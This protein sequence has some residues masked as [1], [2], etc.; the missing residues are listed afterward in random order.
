MK[1][2]Q[3]ESIKLYLKIKSPKI[4]EEPYYTI[5]NTNKIFSLKSIEKLK[6]KENLINLTLDEIFNEENTINDIYN[7]TCSNVIKESLN[8]C[9]FCL[10]NHGETISDKL[11]TFMGDITNVDN[12]N[13]TKGMFQRLYLDLINYIEQNKK[14][15]SNISLQISFICINNSKVIDLNNFLK[16]DMSNLNIKNIIQNTKLIQ[17]DK[18]L[19][20]TLK[21]I[22]LTNANHSHILKYITTIISEFH[23][24][25]TDY[26]SNS[27][28]SIIIYIDKKIKNNITHISSISFILLNGSEKLNIVN[29]VKIAKNDN[30]NSDIK[31]RAIIA[32]KNAISTQH[33]YNSIIYL[34]KKNKVF[35]IDKIK[36]KEKE[37]LTKEEIKEIETMEGRYISSLTALLYN[38]CFDYKIENIKYIIFADIYPNVGYYKSIKDSILFLFD[39]SKILNKNIKERLNVEKNNNF[40]ETNFM[41]DLETKINQQEQTINAL[42]EICQSKNKKI[43]NL[44]NVYDSQITRLKKIFGFEGDIGIL[45]SGEKSPEAEKAKNIRESGN[46]IYSLNAKIKSMEKILKKS[47]DEIEKYKS[48][49]KVVESDNNMIKYIEGIKSMKEDKLNDMH[50]KSLYGNKINSLESELKNKN[51][52]INQLKQDLINKNNIIQKLSKFC[53]NK[54]LKE[55]E[56]NEINK[57]AIQNKEEVNNNTITTDRRNKKEMEME[58]IIKTYEKKIK[59]EHDFWLAQIENKDKDIKTME[60]K[61]NKFIHKEKEYEN[62]IEQYKSDIN[63]LNEEIINLKQGV[64][65]NNREMMKLNELLMEIINNYNSYFIHKSKQN[66]NFVSLQNKIKEFNTYITEKEKEI[67]QLN[68]PLLH[69][70]LEKNNKLSTNYKTKVDRHIKLNLKLNKENLCSNIS[71]NTI[72]DKENSSNN[73]IPPY[74]KAEINLT[75]QQLEEMSS[76]K[77]IEYCLT[78]I[79]RVNDADKYVEKC[80]EIK[81]ENEENKKQIKYLNFKL[82]RILAES[83][84]I[85][86]INKN[87]KIVIN[88][89]NRTIEKFQ[90]DKL[91]EMFLNDVNSMNNF[92]F[93]FSPKKT[94]HFNKSQVNLKTYNNT[95]YNEI[96]NKN[97]NKRRKSNIF[98]KNNSE[99]REGNIPKNKKIKELIIPNDYF[100]VNS[101]IQTIDTNNYENILL[102]SNE[103]KNNNSKRNM[104]KN[105]FSGSYTNFYSQN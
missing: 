34:I 101:D 67:N 29:N 68:F 23:K 26:F 95:I 96:Y 64:N 105:K 8:G 78:L 18:S 25:N 99:N 22:P 52:I 72:Q 12:M 49:E 44:E 4:I 57:T 7:K 50:I 41:L 56:K 2:N 38:I 27:Y 48:K 89:Q 97:I 33:I 39:L 15:Y 80:Q 32:S 91:N 85:H 17:N 40:F 63:K 19:I 77:L 100:G 11:L 93:T 42:S 60:K 59:D 58:K 70:L 66:I 3:Q 69:I 103:Y 87:N 45:L 75:K 5:D 35:N 37:T 62:I 92:G 98:L 76:K 31:K 82:K 88:S 84:Q 86:E 104:F 102:K 61:Y 81:I 54:A 53:P 43:S 46:K 14:E 16:K 9:S 71:C 90:T 65:S 13:N 10:V 30:T 21:K 36:N 1:I 51:F 28:F 79:Q 24:F 55:E 74:K 94:L 20:N 6:T 73:N 47:K 83:Q